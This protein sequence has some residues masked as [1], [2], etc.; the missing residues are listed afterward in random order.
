MNQARHSISDNDNDD[1]KNDPRGPY[2]VQERI[3]QALERWDTVTAISPEKF[4]AKLLMSRGY[5]TSLFP[6]KNSRLNPPQ[7]KQVQDYDSIIVNSVRNSDLT[8]LKR[9]Y[10]EG[11]R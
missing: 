5:D 10:V 7:P 2:L 1:E 6:S 4:L 9:L 11:R 3:H 8:T